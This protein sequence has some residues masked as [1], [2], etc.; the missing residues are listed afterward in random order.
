M[1]PEF[2][3]AEHEFHSEEFA[4]DWAERFVPTPER[5]RLFE[6]I[7]YQAKAAVP[8]DGHVVELGIDGLG[9]SR[10]KAVAF[11]ER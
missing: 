1:A 11:E 3:G 2:V 7:L 6:L 8:D 5:L 4:L 10:Q 9:S